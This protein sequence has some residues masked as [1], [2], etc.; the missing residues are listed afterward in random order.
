[1]FAKALE[2]VER[3]AEAVERIT[4]ALVDLPERKREL[5]RDEIDVLKAD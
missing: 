3:E 1:M 2:L 5:M 4:A